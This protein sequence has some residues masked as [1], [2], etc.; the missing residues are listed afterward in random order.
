MCSGRSV[1]TV[2]GFLVERELPVDVA[3]D[4]ITAVCCVERL[5]VVRSEAEVVDIF[6]EPV[7]V[8]VLGLSLIHI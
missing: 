3:V 4:S 1:F 5:C 2:T 8:V 6:R 7:K